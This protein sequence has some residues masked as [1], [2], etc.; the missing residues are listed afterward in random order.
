MTATLTGTSSESPQQVWL[1]RL[2][3]PVDAVG[4]PITD[5]GLR[6]GAVLWS[7][8]RIVIPSATGS[9]TLTI[10]GPTSGALDIVGI[11]AV[12]TTP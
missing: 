3:F 1:M 7:E 8:R 12:I 2:R 9:T 5:S 6:R 4:E 10:N 11:E